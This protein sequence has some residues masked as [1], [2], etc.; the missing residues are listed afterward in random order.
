MALKDFLETF[1]EQTEGWTDVAKG[2]VNEW[3]DEY[4]KA[5]AILERFGFTVGKFTVGMGILPEIHTSI[6]GSE[7]SRREPQEDD[8]RASGGD[9]VGFA[10]ECADHG[11]AI[12]GACGV[13]VDRCDARRHAWRAAEYKGA[14]PLRYGRRATRDPLMPRKPLRDRLGDRLLVLAGSIVRR[15]WGRSPC[16]AG[17]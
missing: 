13:K 12:L 5:I 8:Q 15:V 1:K 3:L 11:Q 14:L 16:I 6:S 4:K 7:H 17:N 10:V 9:A 2:K